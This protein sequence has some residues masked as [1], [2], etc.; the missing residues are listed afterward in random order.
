MQIKDNRHGFT[1]IELLVVMVIIAIL[2]GFISSAIIFTIK[3]SNDARRGT[4]SKA[5]ATAIASYHHKY[6]V[7][8]VPDNSTDSVF[9]DKNYLVINRLSPQDTVNNPNETEFLDAGNYTVRDTTGERVSLRKVWETSG[10]SMPYPLVGPA[11]YCDGSCNNDDCEGD[12]S[13][14]CY[15]YE[16]RFN[17]E[18]ETV[19]V[20]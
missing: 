10:P 16:I 2:V 1:L 18:D 8:P 15:D 6:G 4:E 17:F 12:K 11:P 3:G 13:S 20:R 14:T 9:R 5:I 7:W 19:D